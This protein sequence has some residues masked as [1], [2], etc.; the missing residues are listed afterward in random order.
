VQQETDH[1]DLGDRA[2]NLAT[3]RAIYAKPKPISTS[4]GRPLEKLER[5]NYQQT[6]SAC[7]GSGREPSEINYKSNGTCACG[8]W[9]CPRP[10]AANLSQSAIT[11]TPICGLCAGKGYITGNGSAHGGSQRDKVDVDAEWRDAGFYIVHGATGNPVGRPRHDEAALKPATI[12]QRKSRPL[13]DRSEVR[14]FFTSKDRALWNLEKWERDIAQ[15]A[16][17][18]SL[19]AIPPRVGLPWAMGPSVT[20]TPTSEELSPK[21]R[22]PRLV[23]VGASRELTTFLNAYEVYQSELPSETHDFRKGQSPSAA[24]LSAAFARLVDQEPSWIWEPMH[25]AVERLRPDKRDRRD[26]AARMEHYWLEQTLN[27][28]GGPCLCGHDDIIHHLA[29]SGSNPD[30]RVSRAYI[31]RV[32]LE[33]ARRAY[34][35][36]NTSVAV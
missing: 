17:R 18:R 14:E 11:D 21:F 5:A 4:A 16:R 12:R 26:A 10:W 33:G 30:D 1:P 15:E 13:K 27:W 32:V 7:R 9:N 34:D 6:C 36:A 8:G 24:D 25:A 31:A 2:P 20:N 28:R 23:T 22:F 19:D 29:E 35:L 3:A